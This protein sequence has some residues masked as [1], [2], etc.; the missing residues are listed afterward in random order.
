MLLLPSAQQYNFSAEGLLANGLNKIDT[1]VISLYTAGDPRLTVDRYGNVGIGIT[2]ITDSTSLSYKLDV[3]NGDVHFGQNITIDGTTFLNGPTSL[4]S[5]LTLTDDLNITGTLNVTGAAQVSDKITITGGELCLVDTNEKI[6]SDGNSLMFYTAGSEAIR[7]NNSGSVGIGTTNPIAPLVVSGTA[8]IQNF[9]NGDAQ[10]QLRSGRVGE[11]WLLK[12]GTGVDGGSNPFR[13]MNASDEYFTILETGEVGIGITLPTEQLHVAGNIKVDGDL[14]VQGDTTTIYSTSISV[15][16]NMLRI[17]NNNTT[18]NTDL[19]FYGVYQDPIGT[20]KFTGLYKDVSEG[21]WHLFDGDVTEP[22]IVHTSLNKIFTVTDTGNVGIGTDSPNVKLDVKGVG[23]FLAING[24]TDGGEVQLE[25]S[26]NINN[27]VIESYHATDTANQDLRVSSSGTGKILLNAPTNVSGDF[28]VGTSDFYVDDSTGNVGI[29]TTE[30]SVKLDLAIGEAKFGEVLVGD[31]KGSVTYRGIKHS[32][33]TADNDAYAIVQNN[34]GSETKINTGYGGSITFNENDD[35]NMIIANGGNV[36]IGVTI[37][38][39]TLDVG[40]VLQVGGDIL[41]DS[42]VSYDIGT[43][44]ARFRDLYL[45]GTSINLGDLIITNKDGS[46][47]TGDGTN[48]LLSGNVGIGTTNPSRLLSLYRS[49][50]TQTGLNIQNGTTGTGTTNGTQ[51]GVNTDGSFFIAQKEAQPI[52]FETSGTERMRILSGGN[53]GIGTTN[54]TQKLHVYE[55]NA[56]GMTLQVSNRNS[57]TG[58]YRQLL[59]T[60]YRDVNANHPAAAIR[61]IQSNSDTGLSKN[62]QLTFWT[63]NGSGGTY[64]VEGTSFTEKMRITNGGNVGIGT[65]SPGNILHLYKST[66]DAVYIKF[67]NSDTN[68]NFIGLDATEVLRI[69]RTENTDIAFHTN[70]TERMRILGGGNVGIGTNAPL[71][72]LDVDGDIVASGEITAFGT[73]SD[74]RLKE[75]IQNLPST[76]D[77]I[78]QLNP[79]SFNWKSEEPIPEERQGKADEGLLAQELEQVFPKAV[80]SAKLVGGNGTEY[81]KIDYAKLS[82]Y[83]IKAMQEQQTQINELKQEIEK[84]K[85]E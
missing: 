59:F 13:I 32:D 36:G 60:G 70:D 37:P 41:P 1:R 81:K 79:V 26:D 28:S 9:G 2:G 56:T 77:K 5:T 23:R 49:G 19:G 51:I 63:E 30:P 4:G 54:P 24:T 29:G 64:G 61:A 8:R 38:T 69:H 45:S 14:L 48:T 18:N 57:T 80:G 3:E 22:G 20:T 12:A 47:G 71:N 52:L 40:G 46:L 58:N 39:R 17:A 55:D 66:S 21:K 50:A 31:V 10:F 25:M 27:W 85:S 76:I 7:I 11:I 74:Q 84:L 83:L 15:D 65:D 62:S 72:K 78:N 43:T 68:S 34:I 67:Q 35:L 82:I 33:L 16:D 44:T 53:V 42:N 6:V 73:V 75:N